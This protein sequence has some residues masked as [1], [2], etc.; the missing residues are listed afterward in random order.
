MLAASEMV[1]KRYEALR[2]GGW[3]SGLLLLQRL[4]EKIVVRLTVET[5][6]GRG[7]GTGTTG[8]LRLETTMQEPEAGAEEEEV[9]ETGTG[10]KGIVPLEALELAQARRIGMF[11]EQGT[12]GIDEHRCAL[13]GVG[14]V[15]LPN[16]LH[17]I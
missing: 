11:L 4:A 16:C 5:E 9:V 2:P 15:K 12:R 8:L 7:K 6:R 3:A 14:H 17:Y 1:G 13:R 10:P